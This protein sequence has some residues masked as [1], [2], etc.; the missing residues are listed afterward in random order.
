MATF[1]EC[2][3]ELSATDNPG[4]DIVFKLRVDT[5]AGDSSLLDFVFVDPAGNSTTLPVSLKQ[6][7]TIDHANFAYDSLAD[8]IT[9][10]VDLA[11]PRPDFEQM[12][13]IGFDFKTDA[14]LTAIKIVLRPRPQGSEWT[15][16]APCFSLLA[17]W[18][19][20]AK[21]AKDF[22]ILAPNGNAK[23]VIGANGS[24]EV[25][26]GF[27]AIFPQVAELGLP[28]LQL[29]LDLPSF[30]LSTNWLPLAWFEIDS[31]S[32]FRLDGLL[33][34]FGDL[35]KF[36]WSSLP[37]IQIPSRPNWSV[38]LP[39]AIDLPLGVGAEETGLRLSRPDNKLVVTAWA[40]NFYASWG[41]TRLHLG[42]KIE[43][44]Y[45]QDPNR[46]T[47][48]AEIFSKQYPQGETDPYGFA[49]PFD[50]LALA[51]DCW[52]LR[53]GLFSSG[54]IGGGVG[55][56]CFEALLEIGGLNI[57]SRF[58]GDGGNQ[59]LYRTDVRLLMRD[60]KVISNSM[61][62]TA[63]APIFFGAVQN[64]TGP[65]KPYI[66][67][68]IEVPALSF[69]QD[70]L[71]PP[72]QSGPTNDYG[73]EFLDGD[74]RGSE[75]IY[76][77]WRQKGLRFLRAL[78]HDLLGREAA[79]SAGTDETATLF[80]LE[81]ARFD[82]GQAT[83]VR[84]DWRPVVPLPLPVAVPGAQAPARLTP[85]GTKCVT[86][87]QLENAP[88]FNVPMSAPGV[89][90]DI[91][92]ADPL[93]FNLPA[94]SLEVARAREQGIVLRCEADG[95][96]SV[97]HL[98]Y[99]PSSSGVEGDAVP[100]LA[101][102]RLGFSLKDKEDPAEHREVVETEE[103]GKF[104]T[105]AMGY[106]GSSATAL[107]TIGW[108][109]GQSPRFLQTIGKDAQPIGSLLPAVDPQ[110]A[111]G[112]PGCPGQPLPAL[113]PA[114]FDFN[115]FDAPQFSENGWRLSIKVAAL[116]CLFKA[117][118]NGSPGQNVS[119]N[120]VKICESDDQGAV[121]IQTKL[122]FE[123]G[124]D[125]TNFSATGEV[126]FRFD[127]RDLA[128]SVENGAELE[129]ALDQAKAPPSWAKETPLPAASNDYWYS[130]TI[131]LLGFDMTGLS[132]KATAPQPQNDKVGV[133]E[134]SI[135]DGRFM[136]AL[137]E[138]RNLLLRYT[139]LGSDSLNF[140]VSRFVLGPGGLDLDADLLSST[141]T[142][143][144][145]TRPFLLEKA[146][147]RIR[148]S[149]LDYLSVDASGKLPELFNEA[150]V[151]L[152]IAFAQQVAG[153][154]IE[155][156]EMHCELG[157]KDSPI[158]SRGTRFKFE[159]TNL[160]INYASDAP[161]GERHFFFEVSGSA[162]FTPDGDEFTAGLLED[163]K[164]ARIEFLRAPLTDEF[165][166]SLNLVV[167]LKRP[168]VFN[169]FSL[170]RME[171]RSIGFAP[172]FEGFEEPG[173]AVI[174]GGQCEFAKL[175]N[176]VS[177]NISFH[178]M[179]IG[180]PKQGQSIPQVHFDGLRVDISS[181][182]GFRIAG[183]VDR[184]N[185]DL[186]KGFAGEGTVQ[187]PGFPELS[188]A[189]AFVRLWDPESAQW[190]HAWFIAIEAAKISYQVGPLPIYLRQ[191][192][193]GFGYRYTL[194][195]IKIFDQQGVTTRELIATML[196]ALD[197]HQTLARI[198]SWTAQP[199]PT[200]WTIALEAVFTLATA[201]TGP[202]AYDATR[203]QRLKTMVAQVLA[204]FRSDFTV[205]A[206]IKVWYPVS[207]DD[208][209]RDIEG[210]RR[211]P[212][213]SGF[214]IYS[215][216]QNRF[217]AHATKGE[218]PYMG[219]PNDPVPET[220][221][222]VLRNSHYEATLL[223]EPGL[224]HGE[225][226]WP[227]RLIFGMKIGSLELECRGGVMFR[228]ERDILIQ[229]TFFS[230]R[231]TMNLAGGL[232]AGF[233]GVRVEAFVQVQF[234]VR[235]LT[236]VYLANPLDSKVY[237]ALGL[238]IAVRF[239]ISAW[240]HLKFGFVKINIDISFSLN[241]QIIVAL[242][243]GW[244]GYGQL[245]F[246]GRAQVT[247]G[248][249]GR[250]VGVGIA[251][252]LNEGGVDGARAALAPYMGSLLGPGETP[253]MP[254]IDR[255]KEAL[256]AVRTA[257]ASEGMPEVAAAH[258]ALSA[259]TESLVTP[260]IDAPVAAAAP[261]DSA[262]A[263]KDC[264]VSAHVEG[265]TQGDESLWFV[266]IMPG[267]GIAHFY[268]ATNESGSNEKFTVDYA[269]LTLSDEPADTA[270][271]FW[272]DGKWKSFDTAN[273]AKVKIRPHARFGATTESGA[274]ASG[275]NLT[276][277]TMIAGSWVP[278]NAYDFTHVKDKEA[279][280]FPEYWPV[281]A[282]I[283]LKPPEPR[284]YKDK[285]IKDRR[286]GAADD[287]Q[288]LP[289][290]RLDLNHPY[291]RDLMKAVEPFAWQN[292]EALRLSEQ[293]LG[294]QNF[295]IQAF[296][297]DLVKLAETTVFDAEK[298]P[299]SNLASHQQRPTL[300]DTGMVLC[301][302]GKKKP[303]WIN[304]R[305]A[306]SQSATPA[307][308]TIKFNHGPYTEAIE[309]MPV[310]DFDMVDF[311]K[312]KPVFNRAS[313][314]FDDD[315][316]ALAWDL[317]WPGEKPE[318]AE[319]AGTDVES[320]L[321]AYEIEFFEIE[322]QKLIRRCTTTPTK[323]DVPPSASPSASSTVKVYEQL[324]LRY[325]FTIARSELTSGLS[326]QRLLRI[327]A[328]VRPISQS[329]QRGDLFT[330]E[331][332]FEPTLTP[333]PAD[334][335]ELILDS[336]D[337][338]ENWSA[339]IT[340]RQL[341]LPPRPGVATTEGWHLILRP[342]RSV[343]LG[344]YPDDAVD[345][346]ERGL[347]SVTGQALINGDILVKLY[348][349]G[350]PEAERAGFTSG[351]PAPDP[352]RDPA[353]KSHI[354]IIK[355]GAI[356]GTVFDHRGA[357][358]GKESPLY[359][360]AQS[361]FE[362][363]SAGT[364]SGHAWRLF[365]RAAHEID[366]DEHLKS[367]GGVSGLA[368]VRLLLRVERQAS[369]SHLQES[370]QG[371]VLAPMFRTLSHFEWPEPLL[372]KQV[373][374]V[375]ADGGPVQ[376]A[377]LTGA[378]KEVA[379][380]FVARPGRARAINV[381]WDALPTAGGKD[382]SGA[383][384]N[385]AALPLEAFAAYDVFELPLDSLINAD[386]VAGSDFHPDWR[387]MRRI[388]ATDAAQAA[389]IPAGMADAQNWE[390]QYPVF[391][392]TVIRLKRTMGPKNMLA[393]WPGWYSWDDSLLQWPQPRIKLPPVANLEHLAAHTESAPA[394]RL[395]I[396]CALG[397]AVAKVPLH[398]YLAMLI[399]HMADG[400]GVGADAS[401]DV[402]VVAGCPTALTDAIQWLAANTETLDPYGW[403]ALS[404]LGLSVTVAMRDP[405]TGLLLPQAMIREKLTLASDAIDEAATQ[406]AADVFA[407]DVDVDDPPVRAIPALK[408]HLLF[409]LPIQHLRAY[410]AGSETGSLD[411][412]A[413]S[414][415]QI[416]LRPIP[417]Q[418]ARY[419]VLEIIPDENKL[420]QNEPFTTP[421]GAS[422]RVDLRF[423][424]INPNA[425]S[426]RRSTISLTP[427][428]KLTLPSTFAI[429]DLVLIREFTNAD[430]NDHSDDF[431]KRLKD[432]GL[433][434]KRHA[435][436]VKR[437]YAMACDAPADLLFSPYET[438]GTD[439]DYWKPLLPD[440]EQGYKRF[441]SYLIAAFATAPGKEHLD[442]AR[443]ALGLQDTKAELRLRYLSWSRRFFRTAPMPDTPELFSP[444]RCAVTQPKTVDPLKIAADANGKLSFT[445]FVEEEWAGERSYAVM[446][447]GRYEHL[448][449]LMK[450]VGL[451][452]EV[453]IDTPALDQGRADVALPRIRR[454]EPPKLLAARALRSTD[455]RQFHELI[456]EHSEK[457]LSQ[458]NIPVLRKLSFGGI[459][460]SY[461][462]CFLH[463]GW[464][465]Q[466]K[467]NQ[468][469]VGPQV[470]LPQPLTRTDGQDAKQHNLDDSVET[471]LAV[472]PQ[473]RWDSSR[474]VDAAEPYYYRQS[475]RYRATASHDVVSEAKS[476]VLPTPEPGPLKPIGDAPVSIGRRHWGDELE[477]RYGE[478]SNAL[479]GSPE[480]LPWLGRSGYSFTIRWPR[481]VESLDSDER[482]TFFA[483]ET[484]RY[485]Y[486]G[487][488][489]APV[490]YLPDP[491]VRVLILD[492]SQAG[493]TTIAQFVTRP[494][495]KDQKP[496]DVVPFAFNTLSA[497]F[498]VAGTLPLATKDWA[499]GLVAQADISCV[500][501]QITI[502]FND[503]DVPPLIVPDQLIEVEPNQLPGP[504]ELPMF[505]PLSQLAPLALRLE[506]SATTPI[507]TLR[508][509]DPLTGG[510]WLCRP[511]LS[512]GEPAANAPITQTDLELGLRMVVD[513]ERR[514]A[515]ALIS[516]DIAAGGG[517]QARA[518]LRQ[519]E[520]S[521]IASL[522]RQQRTY[523]FSV[524]Q[525][526]EWA[527]AGIVL[528]QRTQGAQPG[529]A[530]EWTRLK[531]PQQQE[532]SCN[533]V[534]FKR[535]PAANEEE[536][537]RLAQI[538]E[539]AWKVLR[540]GSLPQP[541]IQ[542]SMV[543]ALNTG[544]AQLAALAYRPAAMREPIVFLQRGNEAR[545]TWPKSSQGDPS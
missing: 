7:H 209:F 439:T 185:N 69:A 407:A 253:A 150:P 199:G 190:Q 363:K 2:P 227:D 95:Q 164:S 47:F 515:G 418:V 55:R 206:A 465:N 396:W 103:D 49:L 265:A 339:A 85:P 155:L 399:G 482:D 243:L 517:T 341:A 147:L 505:G 165:H 303:D 156:D 351:D 308:P 526:Q 335:A 6:A 391:A 511:H 442:A 170:F 417:Q 541:Q 166:K 377:L 334:K 247:I 212:L 499:Q 434:M 360:A 153:G 281:T 353:E 508:M 5:H 115:A 485:V 435:Q 349:P 70:L 421:G 408:R 52:Y 538:R 362:C 422:I 226:G 426:L 445:R 62:S 295:L 222:N 328:S 292:D 402:Q 476:V 358:Q 4:N 542:P 244:A 397:H 390:A 284:R 416:S 191:I 509:I 180:L 152:T 83:Q 283:A 496:E 366:D 372:L 234:A 378:G 186:I 53:A 433:C 405:L 142:V 468:R 230:A 528:W 270:V 37:G 331:L 135:R 48:F 460:R 497:D 54:P 141:I 472:A 79:G 286:V 20:S 65:F 480:V 120:I 404:H 415:L 467:A 534:L 144:G 241:L 302:R 31:L 481:L 365:L 160:T 304:R 78:A 258:M 519:L 198:D 311:S 325:Q 145:L 493:T 203:E 451:D 291:D 189:F 385:E 412:A 452:D 356:P 87:D 540:D 544:L 194:P 459:E 91:A 29:R 348:P 35:V 345:V 523:M 350:T 162:Q 151:D 323:Y 80:G 389:Q 300:L 133:L 387:W 105:V 33:R 494:T 436:F 44:T 296:H 400:G 112:D 14:T 431:V 196:K 273:P 524:A 518:L 379:L 535:V 520:E 419:Y 51:A 217:L 446:P 326:D 10:E 246:K 394:Q 347:M 322:S 235:L 28:D 228:L 470:G 305:S 539:I 125:A 167:E 157:D 376:V 207:V 271:Y 172:R 229:G 369:P 423:P 146:S 299:V 425:P 473:A 159:I 231:G 102:A 17:C 340:W 9:L 346:T 324:L 188:A 221:K 26:A 294:N 484:G 403:A 220:L 154:P 503:G 3:A 139:K 255:P 261:A 124:L 533:C 357:P 479:N 504:R 280:P 531:E 22:T 506:L 529:E 287:P 74:F 237:A 393:S 453:P 309:V 30:G 502:S 420:T 298:P 319:F 456:M 267:P 487:L 386:S 336:R 367:A 275:V 96:S 297:D 371:K 130:E 448:L 447:V 342:L 18:D 441:L 45:R 38:D 495:A 204:G 187:I 223:I 110:P 368:Q 201:N 179:Y 213:V 332:E 285:K 129:F 263:P 432:K 251:V 43:L 477:I 383:E 16:Q 471:L 89:F 126:T 183:R 268:P 401:Y 108:A 486:N 464:V 42:G 192:G 175:G 106:A 262:V 307:Y 176:V 59:G 276:L 12:G 256:V 19:L 536:E 173:V 514:R 169:V 388:L 314:Y 61:P 128:L 483:Y 137:P 182:E 111:E 71:L 232:D 101:R 316:V 92:P 375:E 384:S 290:R 428:T 266:W 143:K 210:M 430:A 381:V 337:H 121:L 82:N 513:S 489:Y 163:L 158:M 32:P 382:A 88:Q 123:F 264:F 66:D 208:F 498:E 512:P 327:G 216:P 50:L 73:M 116:D 58:A 457:T 242:E 380:R 39:L 278:A 236:A 522:L 100:P 449:R 177:A 13:L 56:L 329:G 320:Y 168:V 131:P 492:E 46:Y 409:E 373:A 117:F 245:G 140:W 239:S 532:F 136:L 195:L 27:S 200:T 252:G 272:D 81:I 75:R 202:Y 545:V 277:Q 90:L 440:Q 414:M 469:L 249:F 127:L 104:L 77:L 171:I 521:D 488:D 134:L 205:L 288:G 411:D 312:N 132:L 161:G 466:L 34:W 510:R 543:T 530:G 98:L 392:R 94:I 113:A 84:L 454:L 60:F 352:E 427:S 355:R 86:K 279:L 437:P 318:H 254:G 289:N 107:R 15:S 424:R 36:D 364:K 11:K 313:S 8:V 537:N 225:F 293:A 184:Y 410:R 333:L 193:L 315:L 516:W 240:L 76:V 491:D 233:I 197:E 475:V 119:F 413:L 525:L 122:T 500:F 63:P 93:T 310:V 398:D 361:F 501:S 317:D 1:F 114:P 282:S 527:S 458:C 238:D 344:A 474:Y 438:F 257:I 23:I 301:I 21:A 395:A 181:A 148:S 24:V 359:Q 274:I 149:K 463:S 41:D 68:A 343:P 461:L 72:T 507:F 174:I 443:A 97:S 248:V 338:G 354:L 109:S 138:N 462:R 260:T 214:M 178:A 269:T 67:K 218:D 219:P 215:V 450:P 306:T 224:I 57:T 478:W 444:G 259:D 25:C 321:R 370:R 64:P 455:G 490:G 330:F 99:Y 118:K 406:C 250:S 374:K 211:R 429:G 40:R